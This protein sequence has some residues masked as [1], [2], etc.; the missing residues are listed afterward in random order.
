MSFST[1]APTRFAN[2]PRPL[3]WLTVAGA[4]ALLVW[5]LSASF[6]AKPAPAPQAEAPPPGG[7]DLDLYEAII[8]RVHDGE[9]Y[10]DVAADELPKRGYPTSSILNWRL[11]T[12]VWFFGLLPSIRVGQAVLIAFTIW[13]LFASVRLA[14]REAGT[15]PAMA[16]FVWLVGAFI[17]CGDGTSFLTQEVWAGALIQMSVVSLAL[18]FRIRGVVCAVISLLLRELTLPYVLLCLVIALWKRRW[19][20]ALGWII[21]IVLY[22][23]L[24]AY[25]VAQVRSHMPA[26]EVNEPSTWLCWGGI[27]FV[28][29]T[30]KMNQLLMLTHNAVRAFYLPFAFLGLLAWR[31]ETG[32]RLLF[33]CL[34]YNMAFLAV[35]QHFN[36][37]WGIIDAPLLSMG[38][39]L[40]PWAIRDLYRQCRG[41]K[42]GEP[43][44]LATVESV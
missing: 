13:T 1:A 4:I 42:T 41:I 7:T 31:G 38:A 25:H 37:Y 34:G 32:L 17:W 33:T 12:Y 5:G 21:G 14:A 19:A 3:A 10:Y 35:G 2:C 39:A 28:L 24:T 29:A 16:L 15:L 20:E 43:A 26:E 6:R 8:K 9:P 30:L 27:E 11:P 40:A 22:A 44:S 18:G 36:D 23:A